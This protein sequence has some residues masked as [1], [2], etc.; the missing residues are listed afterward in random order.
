MSENDECFAGIGYSS[1]QVRR[2]C[3]LFMPLRSIFGSNNTVASDYT[4]PS[5]RKGFHEALCYGYMQTI[6]MSDPD[7]PICCSRSAADPG[8]GIVRCQDLTVLPNG[9]K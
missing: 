2:S 3:P 4:R 6:S 8:S 5:S 1:Y 7:Q 9:N